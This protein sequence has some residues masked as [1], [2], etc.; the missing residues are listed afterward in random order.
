MLSLHKRIF[1]S[2]LIN[3]HVRLVNLLNQSLVPAAGVFGPFKLLFKLVILVFEE[4]DALL[5]F[6]VVL[7]LQFVCELCHKLGKVGPV[8]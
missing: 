5:E 3:Q 1:L 7:L 2:E 4:L 8:V 6:L